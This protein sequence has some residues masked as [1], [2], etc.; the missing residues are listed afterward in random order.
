MASVEMPDH[1]GFEN[2]TLM[3]IVCGAGSAVI[4]GVTELISAPFKACS[5]RCSARVAVK[6]R[7]DHVALGTPNEHLLGLK[8]MAEKLTK[9][10]TIS[11]FDAEKLK[12][13]LGYILTNEVEVF[14]D[15]LSATE[16]Q[17]LDE[18]LTW[19][20]ALVFVEDPIALDAESIVNLQRFNDM[21]EPIF[22]NQ[23]GVVHAAT[24]RLT[25]LIY[26]SKQMAMLS[27]TKQLVE[28][29]K[30]PIASQDQKDSCL[31]RFTAN[32]SIE[33]LVYNIRKTFP[34]SPK[35][36]IELDTIVEGFEDIK[37]GRRPNYDAILEA[38][39]EVEETHKGLVLRLKGDIADT[40]E[41]SIA[42]IQEAAPK[43][44]KKTILGFIPNPF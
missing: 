24:N 32:H 12:R 19:V 31:R 10:H 13:E 34:A 8:G 29:L 6:K 40:R 20:S 15:T 2:Y 33:I 22:N 23:V 21:L 44:A 26:N 42:S 37:N 11:K 38:L 9:S 18:T 14:G 43:I 41:A 1:F 39:N 5:R 30:S 35:V 3:N 4:G 36:R 16:H 7:V 25:H 28:L 27:D 17:L